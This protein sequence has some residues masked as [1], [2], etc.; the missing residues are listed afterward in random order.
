MSTA[1][2]VDAAMNF[3]TDHI[4]L[5]LFVVIA[6]IASHA[7]AID[8][9]SKSGR[10]KEDLWKGNNSFVAIFLTVDV[11]ILAYLLYKYATIAMTS[12]P[13]SLLKF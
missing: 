11:L 4:I 5:S 3:A 6:A 10:K 2:L 13:S 1:S 9:I 8:C 12:G 7:I